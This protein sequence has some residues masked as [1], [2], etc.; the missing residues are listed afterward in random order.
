[1]NKSTD[2][3]ENCHP[4]VYVT[5]TQEQITN[6]CMRIY[7]C[8]DSLVPDVTA[9]PRGTDSIP[10]IRVS[11]GCIGLGFMFMSSYLNVQRVEV[12]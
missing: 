2:R 3:R 12:L 7:V 8:N 1:M 10:Q 6:M 11:G 4:F 5:E 9:Q